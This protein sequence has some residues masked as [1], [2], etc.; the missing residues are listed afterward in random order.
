MITCFWDYDPNI[1][2]GVR[3][4]EKFMDFPVGDGITYN[5]AVLLGLLK[6]LD[7]VDKHGISGELIQLNH[8]AEFLIPILQHR[9]SKSFPREATKLGELVDSIKGKGNTMSFV[10]IDSKMNPIKKI[11][12]ARRVLKPAVIR[13]FEI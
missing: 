13:S 3:I 6:T 12:K 7:T 5:H 8:Q 4:D 1:G 10:K 11:L 9:Q 2:L